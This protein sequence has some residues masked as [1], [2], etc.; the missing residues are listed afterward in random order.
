MTQKNL[1]NT[2]EAA[3]LV[4]LSIPQ[5]PGIL[6]REQGPEYVADLVEKADRKS[7][8]H[9]RATSG[10]QILEGGFRVAFGSRCY[11]V[12]GL[13]KDD[14]RLKATIRTEKD[15]HLHIDTVDL[16]AARNRRALCQDLRCLFQEDAHR[17]QSDVDR[18]VRLC[19]EIDPAGLHLDRNASPLS[20]PT[21]SPAE[22]EEAEA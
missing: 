4:G 8:N 6:L 9:G 12:R 1:L 18:L 22:A 5:A 3:E 16:Y 10:V 13:C 15:G 20:C 14:R 2:I 17:V 11:E 7:L 19:E 21:L